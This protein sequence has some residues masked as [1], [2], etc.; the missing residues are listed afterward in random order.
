MSTQ[1]QS[2]LSQEEVKRKLLHL[3]LKMQ[4]ETFGE[5]FARQNGHKPNPEELSR[6][7]LEAATISNG[8]LA[9]RWSQIWTKVQ[10]LASSDPDNRYFAGI[11]FEHDPGPEECL[12]HFL[13]SGGWDFLVN[14]HPEIIS[15]LRLQI[16]N[17]KE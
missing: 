7:V 2:P 5:R 16:N 10:E 11:D 9:R 13:L 14:Q 17:L 6:T 8:E 12:L 3:Y 15:D 4:I 1:T